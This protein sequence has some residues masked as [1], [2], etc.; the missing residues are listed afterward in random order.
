[1]TTDVRTYRYA[2]I[3]IV[4]MQKFRVGC[5]GRCWLWIAIQFIP[6]DLKKSRKGWKVRKRNI[7]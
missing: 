2:R 1:M 4:R 7:R 5:A 6:H 3:S